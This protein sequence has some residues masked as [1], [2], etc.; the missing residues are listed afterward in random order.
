MHVYVIGEVDGTLVKIGRAERPA[1]RLPAL[2]TASH[3]D[4][5]IRA[6]WDG[7]EDD[8]KALHRTFADK[9]VRGEWFEFGE[10]D[11]IQAV[12]DALGREPVAAPGELVKSAPGPRRE[13]R[14]DALPE[15][16]DLEQVVNV[17]RLPN[18]S[19]MAERRCAS[20]C[21]SGSGG[22]FM[23]GHTH[24]LVIS[25]EQYEKYGLEWY[26]GIEREVE[27]ARDSL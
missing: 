8:E 18:G 2:R 13:R 4:L 20:Q 19:V 16:K 3:L 23:R 25:A 11:P 21:Y 6:H 17:F 15:L 24:S 10:V 27:R 9:R 26:P 1:R 5:V 12:T 7:S 22:G 14:A